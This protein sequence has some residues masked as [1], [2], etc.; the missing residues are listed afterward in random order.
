MENVTPGTLWAAIAA[1]LA[2]IVLIA[3]AVEKI[4]AAVK[5]AKAPAEKQDERLAALENWR[6]EVDRKLDRDL[7]RFETADADNRITQMSLLALL[8]HC[9]DGNNIEQLQRAK[10]DLRKHLINK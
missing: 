4:V 3:N 9:I 6:A 2:A 7:E 10:E 1:V 8:D 5:C